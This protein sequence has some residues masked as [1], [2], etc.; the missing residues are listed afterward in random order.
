V[1]TV[2]NSRRVAEMRCGGCIPGGVIKERRGCSQK[3]STV[4]PAFTSFIRNEGKKRREVKPKGFVLGRKKHRSERKKLTFA[5]KFSQR[6]IL[7]RAYERRQ[8][9]RR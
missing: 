1:R 8:G 9:R 4:I 6:N 3:I 5:V 7:R 2:V